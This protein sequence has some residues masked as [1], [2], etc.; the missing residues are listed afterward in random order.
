MQFFIKENYAR[1][2]LKISNLKYETHKI[3]AMIQDDVIATNDYMFNLICALCGEVFV[4]YPKTS[5]DEGYMSS[6]GDLSCE[7]V[8][9]KNIIE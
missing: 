2:W 5:S 3:K 9:I 6:C 1:R 7:E 8:I 4:V